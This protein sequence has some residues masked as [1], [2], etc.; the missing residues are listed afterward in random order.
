[1]HENFEC[2]RLKVFEYGHGIRFADYPLFQ[3]LCSPMSPPQKTKFQHSCNCSE[4][5]P[6]FFPR[7]QQPTRCRP[8]GTPGGPSSGATWWTSRSLASA[9]VSIMQSLWG[10]IPRECDVVF[11]WCRE[12]IRFKN[13][14]AWAWC[15]HE[16]ILCVLNFH[17][18]FARG[19]I[20]CQASLFVCA[21]SPVSPNF[22]MGGIF[23]DTSFYFPLFCSQRPIL[24]AIQRLG[25]RP[26]CTFA[27]KFM[28]K[29]T[30]TFKCMFNCI[31][32][33]THMNI[34]LNIYI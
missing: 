16:L 2:H 25:D 23:S 19:C 30:F 7:R 34:D 12:V 8:W 22:L 17:P 4:C 15:P 24:V 18:W 31:H 32:L 21:Q 13:A 33:N 6:I 26:T 14:S 1:M 28:V 10:W 11:L 27:F 20:C 3:N 29:H 5:E 9:L